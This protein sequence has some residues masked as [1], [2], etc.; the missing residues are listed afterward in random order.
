[1]ENILKRFLSLNAS[2]TEKTETKV[3]PQLPKTNSPVEG[4]QDP[5][6]G[7]ISR[8]SSIDQDQ[9]FY[10]MWVWPSLFFLPKHVAAY[11]SIHTHT[12][13]SFS[14]QRTTSVMKFLFWYFL[15]QSRLL[16]RQVQVKFW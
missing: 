15:F 9:N 3:S 7:S 13:Q 14:I 5:R 8:Q 6:G 12:K 4:P 1:M 2:R 11:A 10:L 16:E